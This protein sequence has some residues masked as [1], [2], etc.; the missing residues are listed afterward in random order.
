MLIEQAA[1]GKHVIAINK[2]DLGRTVE[3]RTTGSEAACVAL[4]AKTGDGID[5]LRAAIRSQLVGAGAEA[6]EGVMVTN[7]RH[8]TALDR[9]GEALAQAKASVSAGMAHEFVAVDLRTAADALGE[10]TGAITTDDILEQ[11]FSTFCV[12]K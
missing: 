9:A 6:T 12:G 10:I 7:V 5:R 8:Q 1:A 2:A 4:S 11:I 3:P